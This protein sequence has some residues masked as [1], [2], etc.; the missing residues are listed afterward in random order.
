VFVHMI[1]IQA[2]PPSVLRQS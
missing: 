1:S 2:S